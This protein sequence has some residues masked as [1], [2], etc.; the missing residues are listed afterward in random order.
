[1]AEGKTTKATGGCLCGAIRFETSGEPLWVAHCHCS[2]CRRHTGAAVATFVGF[3]D[4]QVMFV[5][6]LRKMF[7]SSP[8]VQ[9]GFCNTCGTP[10]SYEG[11]RCEGEIHLHISTMDDP[12]RFP[13]NVH[14]FHSEKISWF[15]TDDD[16]PRYKGTGE[17]EEG[18]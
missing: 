4:E 16:L 14:V 1:M 18:N 17:G 11:D 5:E 8:G 15:E 2:H 3:L 10:I 7:E 12:D 13:A 6:G 9:R